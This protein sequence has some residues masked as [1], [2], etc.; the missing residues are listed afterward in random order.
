VT[1]QATEP[2][3]DELKTIEPEH[4]EP[5]LIEPHLAELD[6]FQP[7]IVE[8]TSTRLEVGDLDGVEPD[9]RAPLGFGAMH[10]GT[11]GGHRRTLVRG[12][13][14][15]TRTERSRV[16]DGKDDARRPNQRLLVRHVTAAAALIGASTNIAS[17]LLSIEGVRCRAGALPRLCQRLRSH[18]PP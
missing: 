18:Q 13:A 10:D 11:G 15:D 12:P 1:Q 8:P 6:V 4:V 7:D 14:Q 5:M 3:N 2:V 17:I 16:R 9:D